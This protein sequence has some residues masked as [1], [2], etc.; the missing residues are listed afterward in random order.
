MINKMHVAAVGLIVASVTSAACA[1]PCTPTYVFFDNNGTNH[2][3]VICQENGVQYHAYATLNSSGCLQWGTDTVKAWFSM[4]EAALMS[5]K[6][7]NLTP[8]TNCVGLPQI[9]GLG[10]NR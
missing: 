4:V 1:Q 8:G 6:T 2:F 10:L 5:G 3:G 9:A 7:L